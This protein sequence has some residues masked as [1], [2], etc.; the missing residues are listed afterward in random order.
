[1]TT[2]T[3][4]AKTILTAHAAT[5]RK[6]VWLADLRATAGLPDSRFDAAVIE[7]SRIYGMEV[8]PEDNRKAI[9]AHARAG[10]V[11]GGQM[12]HHMRTQYARL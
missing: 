2:I 4:D 11:I 10:V 7:L 12:A 6:V 3:A 8:L 1:M 9:P 5:G